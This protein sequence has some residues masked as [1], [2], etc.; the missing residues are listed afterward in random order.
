MFAV[1]K[2]LS[3]RELDL[4]LKLIRE[5]GSKESMAGIVLIV[6][7]T[8]KNPDRLF[9]MF[10]DSEEVLLKK[11]RAAIGKTSL[12]RLFTFRI[13]EINATLQSMN[14]SLYFVERRHVKK[15]SRL[16]TNYCLHPHCK[17]VESDSFFVLEFSHTEQEMPEAQS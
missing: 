16:I 4:N 14:P 11:L 9:R 5:K 12:Y 1:K 13:D 10:M 2:V 3:Q 7:K 6:E 17:I 8:R 15:N